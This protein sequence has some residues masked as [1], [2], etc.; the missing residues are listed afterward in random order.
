MLLRWTKEITMEILSHP[1][2]IF[3]SFKLKKVKPPKK[4]F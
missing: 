2:N 3:I 1:A 4:W